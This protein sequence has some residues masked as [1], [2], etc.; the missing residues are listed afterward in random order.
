MIPAPMWQLASPSSKNK[1]AFQPLKNSQHRKRKYY[2]TTTTDLTGSQYLLRIKIHEIIDD[3]SKIHS[4]FASDIP[5]GACSERRMNHSIATN[6]TKMTDRTEYFIFHRKHVPKHTQLF[7]EADLFNVCSLGNRTICLVAANSMFSCN[8]SHTLAFNSGFHVRSSNQNDRRH[9]FSVLIFFFKFPI[10]WIGFR[11]QSIEMKKTL[12]ARCRS[13]RLFVWPLI[14]FDSF[15][16][17]I[18]F[19]V[20]FHSFFGQIVWSR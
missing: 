1:C 18:Q 6:A 19:H 8:A 3:A 2:S 15:S 20:I 12:V 7:P 14:T 13:F 4:N 5:H 10:A 17:Q 11:I 16:L 9:S